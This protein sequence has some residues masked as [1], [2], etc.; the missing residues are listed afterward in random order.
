MGTTC[1]EGR[2]IDFHANGA[3]GDIKRNR[4]AGLDKC[5]RATGCRLRRCM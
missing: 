3:L 1:H 5:Q 4:V 2:V